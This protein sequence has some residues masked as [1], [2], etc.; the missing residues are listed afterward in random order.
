VSSIYTG[1]IEGSNSMAPTLHQPVET[2]ATSEAAWDDFLTSQTRAPGAPGGPPS[3]T[4]GTDL[5]RDAFLMLLMTQMQHQDPLEPVSNQEMIAQLAQFSTLEQMQQVNTT[6]SVGHAQSLVG[7]FVQGI[8]ED[9][10]R[11][12]RVLVEGIV[13]GVMSDRGEVFVLV[14]EAQIPI[15][16]VRVVGADVNTMNMGMISSNIAMSQQFDLIGQNVQAVIFA[17]ER[18]DLNEQVPIDFVEGTLQ[19]ITFDENGNAIMVIDGLALPAGNQR[20][21]VLTVSTENRIIGREVG[22]T[23]DNA[24]RVYGEIV[25]IGFNRQGD[26]HF[27]LHSPVVPG[28]P[29]PPYEE[30][31]V[32]PDVPTP[33]YENIDATR[34]NIVVTTVP[35][36]FELLNDVA[37]ALDLVGEYTRVSSQHPVTSVVMVSGV[38]HVNIDGVLHSYR[39]VSRSR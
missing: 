14:G 23:P 38:P 3:R 34:G 20:S 4:P 6:V 22:N 9:P 2:S 16:E 30:P 28:V 17:E 39:S 27:I 32:S 12:E 37:A 21:R 33:P 10:Q 7:H 18:N 29:T 5:G 24:S 25:G 26:A 36:D 15:E 31:P 19:H 13:E 11:G 1:G 35:F 8:A